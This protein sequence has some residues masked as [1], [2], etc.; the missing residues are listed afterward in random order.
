MSG[1]NKK[2]PFRIEEDWFAFLLGIFIALGVLL[3]WIQHV[4]W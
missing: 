3:G 1:P 4:P 2:S